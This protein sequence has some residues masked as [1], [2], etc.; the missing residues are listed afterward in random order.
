LV[1]IG[2]GEFNAAGELFLLAHGGPCGPGLYSFALARHGPFVVFRRTGQSKVK[3]H[4]YR[5]LNEEFEGLTT[6]PLPVRAGDAD[7]HAVLANWEV[8]GKTGIYIKH[9]RI[10]HSPRFPDP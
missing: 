1:R 4:L 8:W 3:I 7:I 6:G 10:P 2:G 9:W 5:G